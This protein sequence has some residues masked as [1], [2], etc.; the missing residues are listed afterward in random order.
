MP[1][2]RSLKQNE[3]RLTPFE[4]QN[5]EPTLIV[6]NFNRRQGS[7]KMNQR[8]DKKTKNNANEAMV[9]SPLINANLDHQAQIRQQNM[10]NETIDHDANVI[11]MKIRSGYFNDNTAKVRSNADGFIIGNLVMFTLLFIES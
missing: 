1:E 4:M 11:G 6:A 5:D 10:S 3:N 9:Y 8:S 7:K 2:M